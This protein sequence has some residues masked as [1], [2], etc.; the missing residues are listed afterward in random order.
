MLSQLLKPGASW[1]A[2]FS[3][4]PITTLSVK[5]MDKVHNK[6][7]MKRARSQMMRSTYE[8]HGSCTVQKAQYVKSIRG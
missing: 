7:G 3:V 5:C 6:G 8:I 4:E 2:L 1:S